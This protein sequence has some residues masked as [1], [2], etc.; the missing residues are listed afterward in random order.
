MCRL[1][2]SVSEKNAKFYLFRSKH[3]IFGTNFVSLQPGKCLTL[4]YKID[5]IS[6]KLQKAINDQ[7]KA[8]MWSANLYLAM[9]FYFKRNSYDGFANWMKKQSDEEMDHAMQLADYV[10]KRGG[11]ITVDAIDAVDNEW[12]SPLDVFERVYAH[13]CHVSQLIDA[14]VDVASSERDKASQ[15]FLWGFVREQVEEEATAQGIVDKIK[16]AG[17][18]QAAI[19]M[20]DAQLG[21]RK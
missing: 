16:N 3:S 10:M 11:V 14:L 15:D 2:R 4:K 21:A 7:V 9:S 20:L 8:E 18:A 5:M 6:E 1:S 13:E 19:F 17:E 12:K